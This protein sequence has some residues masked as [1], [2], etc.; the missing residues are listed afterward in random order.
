MAILVGVPHKNKGVKQRKREREGERRCCV[1][2]CVRNS[3][4]DS[5]AF[6]FW[7][8]WIGFYATVRIKQYLTVP[9]HY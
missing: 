2:V 6:S 9:T 3:D 5:F 8:A 1:C 7:D 4:S